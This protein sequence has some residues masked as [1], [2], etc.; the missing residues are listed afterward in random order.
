MS[1]TILGHAWVS[2]LDTIGVI[3]TRDKVT[4]EYKG[5]M[6]HVPGDSESHDL[7]L[8]QEHGSQIPLI[9][10]VNFVAVMGQW[11]SGAAPKE[12]MDILRKSWE[13]YSN[14]TRNL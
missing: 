11:Y 12:F 9:C 14:V 13:F 4:G 7:V 8:I 5:R 2:G 1:S 10:A 6:L 3:V